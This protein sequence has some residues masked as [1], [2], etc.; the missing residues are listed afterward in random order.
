MSMTN[1][2]G[3]NGPIDGIIHSARSHGPRAAS[4][5]QIAAG[6]NSHYMVVTALVGA[7]ILGVE[8]A[9]NAGNG[10][11]AAVEER[12]HHRAAGN[13]SPCIDGAG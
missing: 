12:L 3:L 1:G 2:G 8:R 6:L 7:M 11:A 5:N 10:S 9:Y 13:P 4:N